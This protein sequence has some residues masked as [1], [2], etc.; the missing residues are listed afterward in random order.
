MAEAGLG[1]GAELVHYGEFTQTGGYEM[2]Q[3]VLTTTVWPT[4]L[5]A[6]NNFIAIGALRA[7]RDAGLRVRPLT[8]YL[9]R[10]SLIRFSR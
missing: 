4:A 2:A 5:F 10:W 1:A 9:R 7:L 6:A 3:R 8:I